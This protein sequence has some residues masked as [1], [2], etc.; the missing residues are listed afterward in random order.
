MTDQQH[1]IS[2]PEALEEI[3][4]LRHLVAQ[5]YNRLHFPDAAAPTQASTLAPTLVQ[6][7][8]GGA[9]GAG[10]SARKRARSLTEHLVM[11]TDGSCLNNGEPGAKAG[12]AVIGSDEFKWQG[13]V[14]G[15]QT[16]N[17]GE[18]CAIIVALAHARDEPLVTVVSDSRYC[19]DAINSWLP[20]WVAKK[21][22]KSD[23]A[24]VLNRDLWQLAWALLEERQR[25]RLPKVTLRYVKAH[26]G[27]ASN[28]RVDKLAKAAAETLAPNLL[29]YPDY[30]ALADVYALMLRKQDVERRQQSLLQPKQPLLPEQPK[31]QQQPK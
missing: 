7:D 21:W 5:L 24:P 28:E 6:A 11:F 1:C 17:R 31:Q 19:I 16:N 22:R 2:L 27:N 23:G 8:G 29:N 13:R 12:A 10:S 25:K 4:R 20:G 9:G 26:S 18:M 15:E 30:P 3:Q 14:P